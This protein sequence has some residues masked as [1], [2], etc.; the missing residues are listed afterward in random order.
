MGTGWVLD[1]GVLDGPWMDTGWVLGGY[2]VGMRN[3]V[4]ARGAGASRRTASHA[5]APRQCATAR[6]LSP[7]AGASR[8]EGVRALQS[9]VL[10]EHR[11]A[12][13]FL[14]LTLCAEKWPHRIGRA[15][16]EKGRRMLNGCLQHATHYTYMCCPARMYSTLVTAEGSATCAQEHVRRAAGSERLRK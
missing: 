16:L 5:G 3:E 14:P 13:K 12:A 8:P 7:H 9:A 2:W 10:S 4:C 15:R 6:G 1:G 11:N